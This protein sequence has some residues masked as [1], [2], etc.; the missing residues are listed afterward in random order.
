MFK[1]V[2][3]SGRDCRFSRER[4]WTSSKSWGLGSSLRPASSG[5]SNCQ[6]DAPLRNDFGASSTKRFLLKVAMGSLR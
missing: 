4:S 3:S 2:A 1:Q 5:I 6:V